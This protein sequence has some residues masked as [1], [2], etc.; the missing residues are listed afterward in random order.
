[1]AQRNTR[2]ARALQFDEIPRVCKNATTGRYELPDESSARSDSCD[3]S[4]EEEEDMMVESQSPLQI[5]TLAER[6]L[7]QREQRYE[8]ELD[9]FAQAVITQQA[10]VNAQGSDY[11]DLEEVLCALQQRR[12]RLAQSHGEAAVLVERCVKLGCDTLEAPHR[13][14]IQRHLN[15]P[16]LF[17]MAMARHIKTYSALLDSRYCVLVVCR[18]T[19][20]AVDTPLVYAVVTVDSLYTQ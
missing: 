17:A 2:T 12:E 20:G 18:A 5:L 14:A 9:A 10:L 19:A 11:G 1:M 3:S 4:E 8:E 6:D 16:V 13:Q 15:A 7:A